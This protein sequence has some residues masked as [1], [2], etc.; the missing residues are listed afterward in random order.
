MALAYLERGSFE[1]ARNHI[2]RALDL[3]ERHIFIANA[4][5][6][7]FRLGNY[8]AA[9]SAFENATRKYPNTKLA[10]YYQTIF[11]RAFVARASSGPW[12]V[13][14]T[15]LEMARSVAA[16]E[17]IEWL[18]RMRLQIALTRLSGASATV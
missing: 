16:S 2:R 1:E 5:I 15:L 17:G 4:A 8:E 10:K 11:A 14:H 13:G 3:D 7:E 18:D 6:I 9:L 12:S